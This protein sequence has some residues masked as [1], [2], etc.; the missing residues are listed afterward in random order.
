V[1]S[2]AAVFP[3]ATRHPA[4]S[5]H[6]NWSAA[7]LLKQYAQSLGLH[8]GFRRCAVIIGHRPAVLLV[9]LPPLT[10]LLRREGCEY[11]WPR[12][13]SCAMFA[14]ESEE[15]KLFATPFSTDVTCLSSLALAMLLLPLLA[16]LPDQS[17]LNSCVLALVLFKILQCLWSPVVVASAVDLTEQGM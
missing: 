10:L 3:R 11:R 17:L 4:K 1:C 7:C 2:G 9:F 6:V 16:G 15:A 13:S 14:P 5:Y 8:S 12:T